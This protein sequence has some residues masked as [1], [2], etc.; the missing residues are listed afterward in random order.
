[1]KNYEIE[2]LRLLAK[3]WNNLDASFLEGILTKNFIYKSQWVL[4]PLIGSDEFLT[5]L[6]FKFNAIKNA[7]NTHVITVCAEMAFHNYSKV[8]EKP[9]LVITQIILGDIHQVSVLIKNKVN[10]INRIDVCFIPDPSEAILTG[11]VPQ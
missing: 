2:N 5:Y 8:K 9:C 10:K 6:Y 3:S 1:M 4:T 7:M 11:E